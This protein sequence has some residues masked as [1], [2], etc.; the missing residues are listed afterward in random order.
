MKT[1][2]QIGQDYHLNQQKIQ[3]FILILMK[4]YRLRMKLPEIRC[5]YC[6]QNNS[7]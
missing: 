5:K 4:D 7:H 6:H 2:N 1:F 3:C